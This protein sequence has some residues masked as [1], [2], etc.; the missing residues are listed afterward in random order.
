MCPN[1]A[2]DKA[3][4]NVGNQELAFAKFGVEIFNHAG[5]MVK[6]LKTESYNSEIT[7]DM[8]GMSVGLYYLRL[9]PETS[10]FGLTT[11]KVIKL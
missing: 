2:K 4:I 1:P 7:F 5:L 6:S 9:I 10:G 3:T 8:T 11:L